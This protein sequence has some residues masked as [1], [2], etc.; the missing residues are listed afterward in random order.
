[1][2]HLDPVF[3]CDTLDNVCTLTLCD[4]SELYIN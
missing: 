2:D 1:M 3:I 4:F